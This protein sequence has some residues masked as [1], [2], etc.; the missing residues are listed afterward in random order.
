M[1]RLFT[2]NIYT[3]QKTQNFVAN[4]KKKAKGKLYPKPNTQNKD[5]KH[6]RIVSV[7]MRKSK[8]LDKKGA[9]SKK[10]K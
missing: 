2:I 6:I 4:K 10:K 9:W 1:R 7:C 8:T 3:R 5:I